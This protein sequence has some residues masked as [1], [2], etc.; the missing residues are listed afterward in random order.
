MA[1]KKSICVFC[2]SSTLVSPI[3]VEAA[4]ELGR[5]MARNALRLIYG[6][7]DRGLMGAVAAGVLEEGG[8]A[9]GVIPRFMV[10]NGWHHRHLT[11]LIEVEDMSERK[12]LMEQISDGCIAL[13]GSVG[14][15]DELLEVVSLK[16][17]GL[18]LKPI[19]IL[20]THRFYAPLQA[21]FTQAI[22]EHFMHPGYAEL[23]RFVETPA[24]A[25]EEMLHGTLAD[26]ERI[27]QMTA[28]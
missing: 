21:L 2:A 13:P 22:E 10:E 6:G 25:V 20:N 9:V 26:S 19:A 28:I 7:G 4:T 18:Y 27:K 8:E 24:E 16:K 23:W 12:K 17:L 1:F 15:F 3:Y 5:L 14:T 11:E